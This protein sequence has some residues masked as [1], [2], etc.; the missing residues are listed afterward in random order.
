MSRK[1]FFGIFVATYIFKIAQYLFL[2][3]RK[4]WHLAD[5]DWLALFMAPAD[6]IPAFIILYFICSIPHPLTGRS[7]FSLYKERQKEL[8]ER[9]ARNELRRAEDQ[10]N[11]LGS[12]KEPKQI[13]ETK[14]AGDKNRGSK[15]DN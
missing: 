4:G 14:S 13:D 2:G 5:A 9:A 11:T 15:G 12:T 6:I 3:L 7:I 8:K 1:T 10:T